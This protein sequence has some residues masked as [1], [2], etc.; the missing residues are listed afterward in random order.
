M[1]ITI[2]ARAVIP[3]QGMTEKWY[4]EEGGVVHAVVIVRLER[5]AR[6][7]EESRLLLIVFA[8]SKGSERVVTT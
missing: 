1:A 2:S 4:S 7:A 5:H 6:S 8:I 3:L